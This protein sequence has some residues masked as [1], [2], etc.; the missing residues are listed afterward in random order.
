MCTKARK[1]ETRTLRQKDKRKKKLKNAQTEVCR[2]CGWARP[3]AQ[4]ILLRPGI[5]SRSASLGAVKPKTHGMKERREMHGEQGVFLRNQGPRT[6]LDLNVLASVLKLKARTSEPALLCYGVG[7]EEDTLPDM[8]R[9][10]LESL[11]RLA[12]AANKPV[13]R[14]LLVG[15]NLAGVA[16]A[17]VAQTERVLWLTS[18]SSQ[19]GQLNNKVESSQLGLFEIDAEAEFD[20]L[21]LEG[22][23]HYL[24]QLPVLEKARQLLRSDG[25]VL[26]LGEYLADDSL[27]EYSPLGNIES[28]YKLAQRLGFRI[29]SDSDVSSGARLTLQKLNNLLEPDE[30]EKESSPAGE[31][32]SKLRSAVEAIDQEFQSGRRCLRLIELRRVAGSDDEWANAEFAAIDSFAPPDIANLFEKSFEVTFDAEV[33]DWKYRLGRGQCVVARTEPGGE[34]V[35]HYGGAP[36]KIEFFGEPEVA[37]QVCDVMVLP[38]VRRS[39]GKSSLFFRTAATF[40]EREIGYSVNHLL[41][42]GFPNQKA[43]NIAIRLGLYEKTDEFVEIICAQESARQ[44]AFSVE[45]LDFEKQ[46]KAIDELWLLMRKDFGDAIIGVRDSDYFDYR[47][48][49][50]PF[51]R[52]GQYHC[53]QICDVQGQLRAVVVTKEH[54]EHKLLLELIAPKV[55]MAESVAAVSAFYASQDGDRGLKF[56]LTRSG[57]GR[58]ELPVAAV[59]ELG[60]EIPCN[61]WNAGPPADKLRDKWWLTAGDMDFL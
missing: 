9:Q 11:T 23:I 15:H 58:V 5:R 56:W 29:N 13:G 55:D 52:R 60:I 25:R 37:I 31:K 1:F 30:P 32:F 35:S 19:S 40:L 2:S 18:S 17:L 7:S 34:I 39:Y 26:L 14:V 47:Y 22:T 21:V 43:M 12:A 51:A 46:R 16:N 50:H 36:R 48:R 10:L 33:W 42:F 20:L 53:L 24:Q 41:G 61:S 4:V 54:G 45:D 57:L 49:Q 8:Q 6:D 27:R 28:L 3:A 38:E 59:N 44:G